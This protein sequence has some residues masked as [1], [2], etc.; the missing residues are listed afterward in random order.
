MKMYKHSKLNLHL[1]ISGNRFSPGLVKKW[2]GST[3][4]AYVEQYRRS[5]SDR[6][7]WKT[8]LVTLEYIVYVGELN[9]E[10]KINLCPTFSESGYNRSS[11]IEGTKIA[12]EERSGV[13][14]FRALIKPIY[15]R[16]ECITKVVEKVYYY[17]LSSW[18]VFAFYCVEPFIFWIF[19]VALRRCFQVVLM[20]A[21]IHVRA[22][23]TEI[24]QTVYG[25]M[26]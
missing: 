5:S 4:L 1:E 2:C 15:G 26:H 6:Q 23:C 13:K 7:R 10:R 8:P 3:L 12:N 20:E 19:Q 21:R 14:N 9:E 25:E 17:T 22:V 16:S 18:A 24:E 11:Y